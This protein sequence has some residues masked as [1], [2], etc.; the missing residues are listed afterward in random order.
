MER[1]QQYKKKGLEVKK[2][3]MLR[4]SQRRSRI[5]EGAALSAQGRFG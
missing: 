4:S 3:R 2:P 5:Q 1:V